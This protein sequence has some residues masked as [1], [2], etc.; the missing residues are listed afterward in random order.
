MLWK[1]K[2]TPLSFQ[3]KEKV[4]NYDS[5]SRSH[6]RLINLTIKVVWLYHMF[7]IYLHAYIYKQEHTQFMYK[8]T[9]T[10][11]NENTRLKLGGGG[12]VTYT[13]EKELEYEDP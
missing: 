9:H 8:H 4:S 3:S 12:I 7:L 2:Y 10:H 5:K 6:K 13:T 11:H 1:T